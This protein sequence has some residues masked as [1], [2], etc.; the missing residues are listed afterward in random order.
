MLSVVGPVWVGGRVRV[1]LAVTC[2]SACCVSGAM[3]LTSSDDDD[4]EAVECF[5]T[6][7]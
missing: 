3:P 1:H 5:S 6:G 4:G 7:T 2:G